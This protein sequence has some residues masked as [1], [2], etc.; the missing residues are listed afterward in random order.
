MAVWGAAAVD[1]A[2][3]GLVGAWPALLAQNYNEDY[4][5]NCAASVL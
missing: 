3:A 1:A 2:A 4:S 5:S